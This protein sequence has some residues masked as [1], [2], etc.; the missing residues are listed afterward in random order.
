M[1]WTGGR[2]EWHGAERGP[3]PL[4]ELVTHS[5]T[6]RIVRYLL[7]GPPSPVDLASVVAFVDRH[8][9]PDGSA[10]DAGRRE[11]IAIDLHHNRLP[12]LSAADLVEYDPASRTLVDGIDRRDER[13]L[14]ELVADGSD[15][16]RDG[17]RRG[18]MNGS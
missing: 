7:D 10:H 14:R 6:R 5:R 8:E 9:P 11:R 4:S 12:K 16:T 17:A 15:R 13:P 1:S 18:R 3:Y 2:S